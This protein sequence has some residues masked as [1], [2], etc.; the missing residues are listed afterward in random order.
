MPFAGP[1]WFNP[2]DGIDGS[3][4]KLGSF[5]VQSDAWSGV[6][7]GRA[8]TPQ[9]IF[10]VYGEL[11]Y[12]IITISDYMAINEFTTPDRPFVRVYEHGYGAFKTH[13]VCLGAHTITSLDYP[14]FQT[15]SNKQHILDRL[16]EASKA[17]AIAHPS[18]R[19][20]YS[21]EDMAYLTGYQLLEASSKF[22][23]SLSHWDAALTAGK[24]IWILSNDDAHDLNKP[25]EF[26]RNATMVHTASLEEDDV[27]DALVSG[28]S[29]AFIPG[30]GENCT[31]EQK[32]AHLADRSSLLACRIVGDSLLV[33]ASLP[34][35]SVR[36]IGQ[37]SDTLLLQS[38]PNGAAAVEYRLRPQDAYVRT[39]LELTNGD[40]F[41]LNPFFRTQDGTVP[42]VDQATINLPATALRRLCFAL[43]YLVPAFLWL[44]RRLM[45]SAPL[46]AEKPTVAT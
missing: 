22:R 15:R 7:N 38:W 29:Y 39:E 21:L 41:L 5:Q 24:P 14:L 20:A 1:I 11:G 43:V 18:L 44:S 32:V 30:K 31:H 13:Q 46:R 37:N 40:R 26:G 25:W 19:N 16:R 12:D 6:T 45:R 9:R 4:W 2:Y 35:R 33:Q 17:V 34:I 36:F 23:M 10:E 42:H 27:I 8:N 28:R 3:E